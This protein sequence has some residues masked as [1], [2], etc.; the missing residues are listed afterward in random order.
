MNR[1]LKLYLGLLYLAAL[2]LLYNAY[3]IYN[4][5]NVSINIVGVIF[6]AFLSVLTESLPVAYKR[7]TI[8]SGFAITFASILLFGT[9]WSMI[10]ISIGVAFRFF[11]HNNK[12]IHIFNNPIYKTLFNVSNISISIYFSSSI[13]YFL[14]QS[15]GTNSK[16]IVFFEFLV[17]ITVF[18][19][20]NTLIISILMFSLTKDDLPITYWNT[21]KFG[22]LNIIAMAPFGYLLA[23]LYSNYNI[24]GIIMIMVPVLLARYTY[25]LYI[26]VKTKYIDTVKILMHAVEARDR[27]TEGHSRNV[28]NI[29]EK[30]ARELKYSENR[31]EQLVIASYLHDV[32]KIGIDDRILNKPDKLTKEEFEIIKTHPEIGYNIVKD[33]KDL[34]DIPLLVRYHHERY[35]GKGYPCGK[36][37]DELSKDVFILQLADAVDAM[38][39]DRIYRKAMTKD[40][41]RNELIRNSGTQFHPEIVNAYL[42][43]MDN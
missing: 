18:L 29:V 24:I 30:I 19:A 20:I 40:E 31:I 5:S 17:I 16:L 23:Y 37:A 42:K 38:S 43:I 2:F 22:F 36:S 12:Y 14:R 8:S 33:I 13:Y 35:D 41:I 4:A 27:Y 32:G 7:T 25:T 1:K 3:T 11:K 10:I 28:A 26:E 9:F 6:F 39:T 34:G 15:L 21:F